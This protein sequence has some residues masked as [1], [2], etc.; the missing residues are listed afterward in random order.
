[1]KSDGTLIGLRAVVLAGGKGTRLAPYTTVLPKPLMP[2]D[3]LP[4]L[5][6]VIRRLHQAGVRDI[7]LSVGYLAS[8]I[9]AYFGDGSRWGVTIHYSREDEPLGTAGPLYLVPGLDSTFLVMNGDLLTTLDYAD[10]VRFHRE[11]GAAVTVGLFKKQVKI[12]LGVVE[13]DGDSRVVGYVEKPTLSYEVSMGMYVMEPCVLRYI[14]SGRR[15]DLPD[16]VRALIG[17]QQSVV[18]YPFEGHWLDI[19]RQEDYARATELF[20]MNRSIF[21][22]N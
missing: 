20:E 13:T 16:L 4:I 11:R 9:E 22:P 18:G 15:F 3:D 7:T 17:D 10:M 6:I 19:G 14:P 12:D 1:M 5:E 8:L 21:L 2:I